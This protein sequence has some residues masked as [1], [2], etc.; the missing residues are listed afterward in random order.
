[1]DN[2]FSNLSINDTRGAPPPAYRRTNNQLSR[3][4]GSP[5][6]VP[7]AREGAS[8]RRSTQLTTSSRPTNSSE[9]DARELA[10]MLV[11]RQQQSTARSPRFLATEEDLSPVPVIYTVDIPQNDGF[12]RTIGT[13]TAG[14]SSPRLSDQAKKA[15]STVQK[16]TIWILSIIKKSL[17]K[18]HPHLLCR[19]SFG[20]ITISLITT[21]DTF[22]GRVYV[23]HQQ[24]A[25][26]H[27]C[28]PYCVR[29]ATS[30]N[31]FGKNRRHF[32]SFGMSVEVFINTLLYGKAIVLDRDALHMLRSLEYTTLVRGFGIDV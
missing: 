23:F 27:R 18:D 7:V 12:L 4:S 3:K 16:A 21:V 17:N 22:Y 24:S 28:L 29:K 30:T 5:S 6:S 32:L 10:D 15:P 1:M 26:G 31:F 19:E 11:Q 9:H 20:D 14:L 8:S 25:R 13:M 2:L